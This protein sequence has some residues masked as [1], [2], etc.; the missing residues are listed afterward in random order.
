MSKKIIIGISIIVLVALIINNYNINLVS[1]RNNLETNNR[2]IVFRWDGYKNNIYTLF[3]DDNKEF[4]SPVIKYTKNKQITIKDLDIGKYY[5]KINSGIINS[6]INSFSILSEVNVI[7]KGNNDSMIIENVGNTNL[8]IIEDKITGAVIVDL[9]YKG[10]VKINKSRV[11][12]Y[13][14]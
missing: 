1:P 4:T 12:V 13:Q 7:A 14:K 3:I 6:R 9:P 11:I 2:T 10:Y 8:S 5:W